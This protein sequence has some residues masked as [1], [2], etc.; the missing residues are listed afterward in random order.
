M[1]AVNHIY[2]QNG[3]KVFLDHFIN[4][5]PDQWHQA[6]RNEFC[7]LIHSNIAGVRCT[8]AID[9]IHHTEIPYDAKKTYASFVCDHRP[10]KSEQWSVRLAI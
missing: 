2:N 9:F 6:L 10:L 3:I 7:R 5:Y 8:D 4:H 1:P